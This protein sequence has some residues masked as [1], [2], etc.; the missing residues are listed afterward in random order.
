MTGWAWLLLVVVFGVHTFQ[1]TRLFPSLDS[2]VDRKSPVLLVDHAIHEDHGALGARFL[3]DSGRTWGYDPFFMA[4]YPETPVWDSSS[5]P[6]ILFAWLDGQPGYRG[7]KVG[8]FASSILFL[9]AVSG[10]AWAAGLRIGEVA[11]ATLLAWFVFWTGFGGGLW[12]AGLFAFVSASGGVGL[13]LGFC[14]RFDRSPRWFNWLGLTFVGTI[15]F[16]FHVTAPILAI[17]GLVAFLATVVPKHGWRWLAA[18]VGAGLTAVALNLFWLVPLWRFRGIRTGS[19]L[20]MTANSAWFL[21]DFV[22]A[23]SIE[24]RTCLVVVVLGFAGLT[25]WWFSGRRAVAAAYGGSIVGLI[26]LTGFGSLWEPTRN[27]E[28]L[29][30]RVG[31]LFLL[32]VPAGSFVANLSRV[33]SE[34]VGEGLRGS[35]AV[36]VV[37][38]AAIG[39][40]AAFEPNYFQGVWYLLSQRRPLVVG[41]KPEMKMLVEWLRANTELSGR[42]LFEDQLRLLEATDPESTHWTPL[43]PDLLGADKRMFIGGIYQT[44]FVKHHNQAAFGDFQLGDRPIDE[45][46]DRQFQEYA[47]RYNLGWVVCWSPLSRFWFDQYPGAKRVAK[48]PRF[49]TYTRPPSDNVHEREAIE[50]RSSREISLKY[51]IEG[52][53]DYVIYRLDRPMTYFLKGKGRIVNVEPDRIEL[54]DVEPQDGAVVISLHWLESWVSEPALTLKPEPMAPDPVDFVRIE[55]NE[56]VGRIV[57]RNGKIGP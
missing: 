10:G 55:M 1:A 33:I 44:A 36:V 41:F 23:P 6:S 20:F 46:S 39:A 28:P 9:A 14:L 48:I 51:M 16:F 19:G 42:I 29:R 54:A 12:R 47:S 37:W 31:F 13:L 30:F 56:P 38:G 45:W 8:L 35:L 15:L 27:L 2:I 25:L 11:L 5:N 53:R 7:Y 18:I 3:R 4:G 52:E 57:L 49:V 21:Y 32:S 43:L 17:G 40:G 24:G 34:R 22:T 50:R 26:L